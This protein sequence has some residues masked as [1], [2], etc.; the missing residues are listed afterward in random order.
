MINKSLSTPW[1]SLGW[2]IVIFIL[3]TIDGSS[4]SEDSG[5]SI[6]NIDKIAHVTLFGV[7][8]IFWWH[9][10]APKWKYKYL[11]FFIGMGSTLYGIGMEFYQQ[12]F[13]S[14]EFEWGDMIADGAG[15]IIAALYCIRI[16]KSPYGNRGR[17]QN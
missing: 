10:L 11:I 17:N 14:R 7:F 1:P 9:Y 8:V 15:S 5:F 12:A 16:K 13:T 3:L 4:L 6:P 2:T